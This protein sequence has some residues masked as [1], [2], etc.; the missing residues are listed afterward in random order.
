MFHRYENWAKGLKWDWCISRQR[1]FGVP[2]P[3]W[4]CK[5]CGEVK[6]AEE[7]Q[8]PVDPV[9]DKPRGACEKCKGKEFEPE[10]DVLDTWATSSLTPKLAISLF[11]Q[12]EDQLFPWRC[13]LRGMILLPSGYLT[14]SSN[15]GFIPKKIRG[16]T[17]L[18]ADLLLT[19]MEKR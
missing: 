12:L 14:P 5:N 3:V 10:R 13:D 19:R 7:A 16:K 18:L 2:I 8:L 15:L 6:V 11:P 4:Y 17:L 1:H 9:E